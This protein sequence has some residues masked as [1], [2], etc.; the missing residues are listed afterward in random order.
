MCSSAS[1]SVEIQI[2]IRRLLRREVGRH[3][4][5]QAPV[6]ENVGDRVCSQ[7][8]T[9]MDAA[10]HFAGGIKAGDSLAGLVEDLGV[11]VDLKS[12]HRVMC[13][14]RHGRCVPRSLRE[15]CFGVARKAAERISLKVLTEL[16]PGFNGLDEIRWVDACVLCEFFKR[17][18]RINLLAV[19]KVLHANAV[20]VVTVLD[21]IR[22]FAGNHEEHAV[23]LRERGFGENVAS[24]EFIHE[25]LAVFVDI[26]AGSR[27]H[28]CA[29]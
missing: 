8:V 15:L 25:A 23:G 16:L 4:T 27:G 7:A 22:A 1:S 12:A 13:G 19:E 2:S 14:R 5:R 21:E 6:V 9:A 10:G 3:L 11:G 18:A 26:D 24:A 29:R 28:L 17:F 20:H